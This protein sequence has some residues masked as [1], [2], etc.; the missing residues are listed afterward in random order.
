MANLAF[1]QAGHP[2]LFRERVRSRNC[3]ETQ[4][5]GGLLG[6][7]SSFSVGAT[8]D[9]ITGWTLS[10]DTSGQLVKVA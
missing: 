6:V 2:S 9:L 4:Q 8:Q 7:T 3:L 10:R 5:F 1:L